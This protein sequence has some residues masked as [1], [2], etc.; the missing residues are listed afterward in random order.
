M[1]FFWGVGSLTATPGCSFETTGLV[2]SSTTGGRDGAFLESSF[3]LICW[4][5]LRPIFLKCLWLDVQ[6]AVFW[7][8]AEDSQK[9]T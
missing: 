5:F 9:A 1:C 4:F 6:I 3:H 7:L 2:A 8:A